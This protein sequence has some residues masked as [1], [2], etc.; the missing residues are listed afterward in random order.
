MSDHIEDRILALAEKAEKQLPEH[1]WGGDTDENGKKVGYECDHDDPCAYEELLDAMGG[2]E[3]PAKNRFPEV[4]AAMCRVV[5]GVRALNSF[6]VID[7][8]ENA[9]IEAFDALTDA[10]AALDEMGRKA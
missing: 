2:D 3:D 8:D 10:L 7:L 6:P 5:A 4:V 1:S 9:Q